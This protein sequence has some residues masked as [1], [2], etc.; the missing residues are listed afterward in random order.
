MKKRR[1]FLIGAALGA[2][3]GLYFS[4]VDTVVVQIVMMTCGLAVGLVISGALALIGKQGPILP[5]DSDPLAGL[6]MTSDDLLQ[7]FWRD[8]GKPPF[9]NWTDPVLMQHLYDADPVL[10]Q[11]HFD[12]DQPW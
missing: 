1:I 10:L 3:G 7:N 2:A 12:A 11:P 4:L 5:F 8:K 9:T 6:G